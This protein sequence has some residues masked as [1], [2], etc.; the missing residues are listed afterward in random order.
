MQKDLQPYSENIE[1]Q[2]QRELS[3]KQEEK[4]ICHVKENP[5]NPGFSSKT[6]ETRS[7][8]MAYS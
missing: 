5:N 8:G 1:S 3:G 4:N 2:R 7:S 6:V